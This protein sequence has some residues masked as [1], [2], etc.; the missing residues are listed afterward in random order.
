MKEEREKESENE[1]E[2]EREGKVVS[3]GRG[4]EKK[5]VFLTHAL[6]VSAWS[7]I[8]ARLR[9]DFR[10]ER[11][12]FCPAK[13]N[14]TALIRSVAIKVQ[15]TQTAITS[16]SCRKKFIFL[17]IEKKKKQTFLHSA[18]DLRR[19]IGVSYLKHL[20]ISVMIKYFMFHHNLFIIHHN[21]LCTHIITHLASAKF[22]IPSMKYFA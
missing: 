6:C 19:L 17:F 2:R 20:S 21:L 16:L 18:R 8:A 1:R 13:I 11:R 12:S 4:R 22:F 15:I 9:N 7:T 10:T 3:V 14:A 5:D